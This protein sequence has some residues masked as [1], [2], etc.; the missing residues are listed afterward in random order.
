MTSLHFL[1]FTFWNYY[2]LNLLRLETFTFSDATLSYINIVLCYVLSQYRWD[3][4]QAADWPQP[5]MRSEA[6]RNN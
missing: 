3:G 6:G 2:V 1:K 4:P 5:P